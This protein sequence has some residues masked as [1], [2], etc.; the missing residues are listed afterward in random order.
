MHKTHQTT[1]QEDGDTLRVAIQKMTNM[2][3]ML[4]FQWWQLIPFAPYD[5]PVYSHASTIGISNGGWKG[6]YVLSPTWIL[7]FGLSLT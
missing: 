6:N 5:K 3:K 7:P 2:F 4:S 1:Y